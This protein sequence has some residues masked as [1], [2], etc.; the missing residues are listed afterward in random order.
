MQQHINMCFTNPLKVLLSSSLVSSAANS[1]NCLDSLLMK[2]ESLPAQI[3][4]Q[5]KVQVKEPKLRLKLKLKL[6]LNQNAGSKIKAAVLLYWSSSAHVLPPKAHHPWKSDCFFTH[7]PC[8][9]G[10]MTVF[11]NTLLLLIY[12]KITH[13]PCFY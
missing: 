6:K 4:S 1:L 11:S 12:W 8:V 7:S 10:K 5:H 3:E 13:A 9:P 2:L